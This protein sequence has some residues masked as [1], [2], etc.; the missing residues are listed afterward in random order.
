MKSLWARNAA[1]SNNIAGRLSPL[2]HR[3]AVQ[4]YKLME[5]VRNMT[6]MIKVWAYEARNMFFTPSGPFSKQLLPVQLH[7]HLRAGKAISSAERE[8]LKGL[9]AFL[10]PPSALT[11]ETSVP[12]QLSP[13]LSG[14]PCGK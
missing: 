7:F 9:D 3:E 12:G 8:L 1:D 14:C 4:L 10:K 6:C 2:A 5:N 11:E 13:S